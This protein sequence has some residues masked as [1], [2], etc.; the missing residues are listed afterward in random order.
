[1]EFSRKSGLRRAI[2]GVASRGG[3]AFLLTVILA[4]SGCA[5][6]EGGLPD[7]PPAPEDPTAYEETLPPD[8]VYD[9]ANVLY[10]AP[11]GNDFGNDGSLA[12]PFRT[13]ARALER[14]DAGKSI[15]LRGGTYREAVRVRLANIT[16]RSQ[17][18]EWAV[19][20]CPMNDPDLDVAVLFDV[21]ASGGRLQR[22]E[23]V[24][25][26]YYG[27]MFQTRWDWGDPGDRTGASR[28]LLEDCR[29]HDTGRDCVKITPGCDDIVIRRCEIFR[30]GRRDDGNAEG[31]DNVN[32]DRMTVEDCRIHDIATNGLY[33]K[34]GAQGCVV[35]RNLIHSC[36]NGGV[37][38]GF[39][40]SPEFFDLQA[41]PGYYESLDGTVRNNII[42]DTGYAGI[43]IY[44]SSRPRIYNNTVCNAAS[45]GQNALHFGISFQDWEPEAKRPATLEPD[46]RNNIFV[47][48]A[49]GDDHVVRIR[50]AD[51]LGGLSALSGMPVMSHNL[52]FR[53]GGGACLFYDQRPGSFAQ[54]MSL[55]QWQAH[56]SGDGDSLQADPLLNG[57][58]KL[59]ASSPA[60]N[61][62]RN[63]TVVR[64][65]IDRVERSGIYDIGGDEYDD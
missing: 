60:I 57:Q 37:M 29:I 46:I 36:G 4:L 51:E 40:T 54:G 10:V 59:S 52:Y 38:V 63:N 26:Y 17:T 50:Y 16:I 12:A 19:I 2:N 32:G 9:E 24:G 45:R 11:A 23:V 5:R 22:L 47:Q 30:S 33:F 15:V 27:V 13:I 41:N 64:Y 28:M 62:G 25:G 31:I 43:G 20:Q 1:M 34:G 49:G 6:E 35:Q 18:G 61:R 14:A 21:D 8:P 58:N 7:D 65:D 44:A 42:V 55:A 56:T 39:D 3:M 48:A 53:I